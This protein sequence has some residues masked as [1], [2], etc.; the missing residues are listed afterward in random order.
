MV[1]AARTFNPP[2]GP[3]HVQVMFVARLITIEKS[4]RFSAL[5]ERIFRLRD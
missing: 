4:F 2:H 3:S 1:N 5:C